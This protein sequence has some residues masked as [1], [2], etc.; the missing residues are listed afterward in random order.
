MYDNYVP[1]NHTFED[2]EEWKTNCY[3]DIPNPIMKTH[4][5]SVF[6]LNARKSRTVPLVALFALIVTISAALGIIVQKGRI[7]K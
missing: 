5:E 6:V 4:V 3:G 1:I 2:D 7:G